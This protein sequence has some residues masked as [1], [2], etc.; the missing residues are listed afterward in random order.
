MRHLRRR[1]EEDRPIRPAERGRGVEQRQVEVPHPRRRPFHPAP[2]HDIPFRLP[3]HV[4]R[5]DQLHE[6]GDRKPG[7]KQIVLAKAVANHGDSA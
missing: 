3:Q 2:M 1:A 4:E 7:P 6:R 5:A